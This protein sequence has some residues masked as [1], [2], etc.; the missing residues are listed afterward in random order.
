MVYALL[1]PLISPP[2][3]PDAAIIFA[4]LIIFRHAY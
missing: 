2:M 1:M 4:T 3:L